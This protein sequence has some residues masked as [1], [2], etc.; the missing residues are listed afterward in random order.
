MNKRKILKGLVYLIVIVIVAITVGLFFAKKTQ[1]EVLNALDR[2]D[3]NVSVIGE[4]VLFRTE[5]FFI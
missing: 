5:L 3:K 2:A 1:Q 4:R